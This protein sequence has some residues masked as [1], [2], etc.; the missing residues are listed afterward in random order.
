[1]SGRGRPCV[2]ARQRLRS[3]N[4]YEY[5]STSMVHLAHEVAPTLYPSRLFVSP[6]A[7]ETAA[8]RDLLTTTLRADK[9]S[10]VRVGAQR[11]FVAHTEPRSP[12][13]DFSRQLER[14]PTCKS[15]EGGTPNSTCS[16]LPRHPPLRPESAFCVGIMPI[17]DQGNLSPSIR[18][19]YPSCET[20]RDGSCGRANMPSSMF[21][22]IRMST[23]RRPVFAPHLKLTA[24]WRCCATSV[25]QP[26]LDQPE[27][28]D[29]DGVRG[30]GAEQVLRF[31][32]RFTRRVVGRLYGQR[33]PGAQAGQGN[34]IR[35]VR[36][37]SA[38]LTFDNHNSVNGIREFARSRGATATYDSD[39]VAGNAY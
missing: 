32:N 21:K 4:P 10:R 35:S 38:L 2:S 33:E 8:A 24:T 26:A 3:R 7:S 16:G 39:R 29:D 19:A 17:T 30:S 25:R 5:L 23:T 11:S 14:S 20:T 28:G 22:G 37:T 1:M 18:R 6:R 31:F 27:L 34:P 12:R 9:A 15:N 13:I 36:A